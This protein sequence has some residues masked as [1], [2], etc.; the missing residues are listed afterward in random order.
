[1]Y[2]EKTVNSDLVLLSNSEFVKK[3]RKMFIRKFSKQKNNEILK[4]SKVIE[5]EDTSTDHIKENLITKLNNQ[6]EN[7]IV[8]VDFKK[9]FQIDS[10][11]IQLKY[12]RNLLEIIDK[13]TSYKNIVNI[14]SEIGVLGDVTHYFRALQYAAVINIAQAYAL[15]L[16]SLDIKINNICI[17]EYFSDSNKST[18]S[19]EF[20]LTLSNLTKFLLSSK[21]NNITG[22]TLSL[23]RELL[24]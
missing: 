12:F 19:D 2:R 22:Q 17:P 3:N 14:I 18:I 7:L 21:S 11:L 9:E 24:R 1:M 15:K 4:I 5:L 13:H 16:G 10:D 23:S 8:L 20:R 6:E